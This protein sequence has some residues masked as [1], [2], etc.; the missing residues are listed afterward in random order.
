[1]G[2]EPGGRGSE[3]RERT[4]ISTF[5]LKCAAMPVKTLQSVSAIHE[6]RQ[7]SDVPED[8]LGDAPL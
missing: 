6:A 3:R 5:G 1:M 4:S 2:C 8:R 7:T